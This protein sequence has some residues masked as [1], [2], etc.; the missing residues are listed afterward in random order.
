MILHSF[1]PKMASDYGVEKAILLY[2][3]LI[4][5]EK[6]AA[7]GACSYEGRYWV[8]GSQKAMANLFPYLSEDKIQRTL[9]ALVKEG[10][11]LKGNF[12]ESPTDR[13]AWYAFSDKMLEYLDSIPQN[14]GIGKCR[15]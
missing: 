8:Y 14:C 2:Y 5:I 9:S 3:F 13:T 7:D 4:W 10:L 15:K 11:L 6:N 12:N 1:I